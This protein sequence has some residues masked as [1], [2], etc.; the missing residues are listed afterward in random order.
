MPF[1]SE[2]LGIKSSNP[3]NFNRGGLSNRW[4]R[5]VSDSAIS[6]LAVV[7]IL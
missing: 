1:I 4:I 2:E 6:V 5:A 3:A 7:K